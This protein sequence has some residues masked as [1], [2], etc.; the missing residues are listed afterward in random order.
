MKYP[1]STYQAKVEEHVFWVA[2]SSVLKGCVGQGDTLDEA[3]VELFENEKAWL[4]AAEEVGISIPK[5]PTEAVQEYSGKMTLRISPSEHAKA[6]KIAKR[7]GIS[8][9]QYVNDAVVAR[10]SELST[11]DY[12]SKN[13]ENAVNLLRSFIVNEV[14][15]SYCENKEVMFQ[16]KTSENS[17]IDFQIH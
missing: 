4:E 6:V 12:L 2:K 9:N 3:V 13:L 1:Y 14:T 11:A 7:E 17:K 15:T 10:N 16:Y 5:I 8:L